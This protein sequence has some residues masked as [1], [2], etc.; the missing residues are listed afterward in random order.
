MALHVL[1]GGLVAGDLDELH[2]AQHGHPDE[3]EGDPDRKDDR[4]GVAFDSTAECLGKDVAFG[5]FWRG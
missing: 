5:A 3:L 4:E 1:V 2:D